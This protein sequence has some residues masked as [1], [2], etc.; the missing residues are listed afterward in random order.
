LLLEPIESFREVADLVLLV[1]RQQRAKCYPDRKI[2]HKK[3]NGLI[4]TLTRTLSITGRLDNKIGRIFNKWC[5]VFY[6]LLK[7]CE[8][9]K[10]LHILNVAEGTGHVLR[11]IQDQLVTLLLVLQSLQ[12]EVMKE[13]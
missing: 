6:C 12:I 11:E 4:E 2:T 1:G 8:A 10:L 3:S 7:L 5:Y 9:S 13:G